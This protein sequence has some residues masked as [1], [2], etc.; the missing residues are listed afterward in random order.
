MFLNAAAE[1]TGNTESVGAIADEHKRLLTSYIRGLAS[2][3]KAGNPNRLAD[4]FMILLDGATSTAL[5]SSDPTNANKAKAA[6][7]VLLDTELR[8]TA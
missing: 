6:A 7:E 2:A 4:W 5:V 3:A 1:F 8:S